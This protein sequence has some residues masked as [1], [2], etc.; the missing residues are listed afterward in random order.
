MNGREIDQ[1]SHEV[2][3]GSEKGVSFESERTAEKKGR[4]VGS[5]GCETTRWT[6]DESESTGV[7]EKMARC[8]YE[9]TR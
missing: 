2:E 6:F 7:K 3:T 4:G 9:R 1:E 5:V 8:L